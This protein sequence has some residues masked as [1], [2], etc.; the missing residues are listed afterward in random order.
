MGTNEA[1]AAA[2]SYWFLYVFGSP[3]LAAMTTA[4]G[5]DAAALA[6]YHSAAAGA[7]HHHCGAAAAD[8]A[9]GWSLGKDRVAFEMGTDP[10]ISQI[11]EWGQA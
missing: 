6:H 11:A 8:A 1:T 10:I 7:P 2:C 3:G 4:C 5:D 9:R